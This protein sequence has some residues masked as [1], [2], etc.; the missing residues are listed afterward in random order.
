[1]PLQVVGVMGARQ[2]QQSH[3]FLSA[4][5]AGL[6]NVTPIVAPIIAPIVFS[7]SP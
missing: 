7:T 2:R 5:H 4:L 1:M 6:F 3:Q